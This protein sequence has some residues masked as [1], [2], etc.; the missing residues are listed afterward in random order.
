MVLQE[1]R[2]R[3][4]LGVDLCPEKQQLI[5]CLPKEGLDWKVELE[6]EGVHC[7]QEFQWYEA[8]VL[9]E[10]GPRVTQDLP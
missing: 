3:D 1:P 7:C 5:Y 10:T 9:L 8:P 6:I 4:E 2:E